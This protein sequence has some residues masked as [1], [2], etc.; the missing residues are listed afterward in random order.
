MDATS[1]KEQKV[2][3]RGGRDLP[4]DLPASKDFRADKAGGWSQSEDLAIG[5]PIT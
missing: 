4:L 1:K 2:N 3:K 5:R